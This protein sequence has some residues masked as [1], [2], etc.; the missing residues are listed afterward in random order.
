M[1]PPQGLWKPLG[2]VF[3]F[4]LIASIPLAIC[5][6]GKSRFLVLGWAAVVVVATAMDFYVGDGLTQARLRYCWRNG[7]Y[8]H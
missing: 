7:D 8:A 5:G 1:T 6:K 2:R 3:M 4:T